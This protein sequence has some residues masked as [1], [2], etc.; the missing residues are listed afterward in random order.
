MGLVI[1]QETDAL[2]HIAI[3]GRLDA[4]GVDGLEQAFMAHTAARKKPALV[5]FSEVTFIASMGMR[6]LIC[7]AQT[8][9][10]AEVKLILIN[11]QPLVRNALEV[12]GITRMLPIAPDTIQAMA[13]LA[14]D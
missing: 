3:S 14:T 11:P 13:L 6:M 2:S 10:H 9:Q 7:A 1:V 8:L 4:A 5:D 12:A